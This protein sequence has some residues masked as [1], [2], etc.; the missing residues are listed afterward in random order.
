MPMRFAVSNNQESLPPLSKHEGGLGLCLVVGGRRAADDDG[1]PTVSTQGVLQDTSHL[2]V[3]VRDV[4][5]E[6]KHTHSLEDD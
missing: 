3:S 4:G 6:H 2:A 5:L 1:G